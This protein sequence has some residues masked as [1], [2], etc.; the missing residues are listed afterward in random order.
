MREQI[1]LSIY[2]NVCRT[3]VH[4]QDI[5]NVYRT[6]L[7]INTQSIKSS[8]F[9]NVTAPFTKTKL[10]LKRIRHK[11]NSKTIKTTSYMVLIYLIGNIKKRTI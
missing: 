7:P 8:I 3:Y 11:H 9:I 4:V 6:Y 1:I 10:I 5:Y 2:I